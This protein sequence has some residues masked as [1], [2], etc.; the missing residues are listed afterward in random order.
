MPARFLTGV[1]RQHRRCTSAIPLRP[2]R[3]SQQSLTDTL[4]R[5]DRFTL[6]SKL[7]SASVVEQ[8]Q[9]ELPHHSNPGPPELRT[10]DAEQRLTGARRIVPLHETPFLSRTYLHVFSGGCGGTWSDSQPLSVVFPNSSLGP[11]VAKAPVRGW[12]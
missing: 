4:W 3:H 2:N 5:L 10:Q 6:G 9:S 8:V 12:V 11:G 7:K 1:S